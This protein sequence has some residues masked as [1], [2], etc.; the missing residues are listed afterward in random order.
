[1]QQQ[2]AIATRNN[3]T[4]RCWLKVMSGTALTLWIPIFSSTV[5][6]QTKSPVFMHCDCRK[7]T[8]CL[9]FAQSGQGS[10][11]VQVTVAQEASSSGMPWLSSVSWR[12]TSVCD[13]IQ[14]NSYNTSSTSRMKSQ[15]LWI[16]SRTTWQMSLKRWQPDMIC[17]S[18]FVQKEKLAISSEVTLTSDTCSEALQGLQK[19]IVRRSSP[20]AHWLLHFKTM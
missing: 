17:T 15:G 10:R 20:T 13:R 11:F 9:L 4:V 18:E 5:V 2:R 19:L 1:M 7:L 14:T 16:S 3:S 12:N 6:V 8:H